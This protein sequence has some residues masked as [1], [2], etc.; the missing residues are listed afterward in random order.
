MRIGS[1]GSKLALTQ[2]RHVS[3]LLGG[4]DIVTIATTGDLGGHT[5]AGGTTVA[6]D[7]AEAAAAGNA[8]KS[9]WVDAIEQALLSGEID[10]AVH[11]AK[12]V[13]AE[14]PQGLALLGSPMRAPV[15]DVIC[16]ADRLDA[17]PPGALVGTSSLRRAAQLRAAFPELAVEPVRGNV[18]TRL[19]K[20]E[21]GQFAAIVLAKAGL[22]RLGREQAIGAALD[23]DGFVPSPG[24]GALALQ[25][26]AG[27]RAAAEAAEAITDAATFASLRAERALAREL[28]ATCNTPLGAYAS[29]AGGG[30]LLLRAWIGLPDGR[31]WMSDELEGPSSDPEQ[32]GERLAQ[33]MRSA[34]AED[35]LSRAEALAP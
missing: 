6:G 15:E 10:L 33:E 7:G 12:D 1:R 35:L 34:G 13:P 2:A 28:K 17:I 24:Q 9:K 21:S 23:P 16:G 27:D 3:K 31:E 30:M 32:L 11:S 26:R 22:H 25:G 14:M 29:P 5:G 8:D 4:P 19:Q 20:L 18:D